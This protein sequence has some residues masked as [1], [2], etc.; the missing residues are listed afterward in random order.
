VER[1]RG[2]KIVWSQTGLNSPYDSQRLPNG[3]TLISHNQGI[4]EIDPSG[5]TVWQHNG[6]GASRICRY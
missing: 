4:I 5:K 3:N 2:G 1:D 6:A